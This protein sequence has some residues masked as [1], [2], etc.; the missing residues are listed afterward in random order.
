MIAISLLIMFLEKGTGQLAN[1]YPAMGTGAGDVMIGIVL[2]LVIGSEFFINY[3][4]IF[5]R[6]PALIAKIFGEDA[7]TTKRKA[8]GG[9]AMKPVV[10]KKAGDITKAVQA[11]AGKSKAPA[12]D[13]KPV[14]EASKEATAPVESK[15]K[16]GETPKLDMEEAPNVTAEKA[17]SLKADLEEMKSEGEVE[18]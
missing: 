8:T 13:A 14:A 2:F 4:V 15:F 12:V 5:D 3:R 9:L 6:T 16:I 11:A 1:N 18:A 7:L 17:G 10:G